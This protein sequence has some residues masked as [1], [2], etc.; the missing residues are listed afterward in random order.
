MIKFCILFSLAFIFI[1]PYLALADE[2]VVIKAVSAS[3]KTFILPKG[4]DEG[5][6]VGQRRAFTT[7]KISLLAHA[8]ETKHDMSLWQIDDTNAIVPFNR[9]DVVVLTSTTE[10]IWTDVARL[11]KDYKNLSEKKNRMEMGEPYYVIRGSLSRGMNES[12]TETSSDQKT[13]RNGMQFEG[14]YTKPFP[15]EMMEWGIG[16]RYDRD[17]IN[18][19]SNSKFTILNTRLILI[20]DLQ[21]NFN[22]IESMNGN[23][24][25]GI[26]AGYGTSSSNV[27]DA[28]T[29]GSATILPSIRFGFRNQL[30]SLSILYE[31]ALESISL[32]EKFADGTAQKTTFVN[33]K[34]SLGVRF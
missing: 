33:S 34:I 6:R 10:S 29:T 30:E 24:Y 11:E 25:T 27:E 4:H 21:Y 9:D 16:G 19:D 26:G 18:I 8:I 31:V 1:S 5:V 12:T 2:V 32:S 3:K 13:S 23:F 14:L 17:A 22:H 20:G 28:T 7:D 15:I